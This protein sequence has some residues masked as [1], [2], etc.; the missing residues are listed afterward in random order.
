MELLFLFWIF[1]KV[2]LFTV[3]GGLAAIPLI[4]AEVISREWLTQLQFADMIAVSESTPGPIGV[5]IATYVGYSQ[6]GAIGSVVATIG[7]VMPSVII[8]ILI[9]KLVKRFRDH[10]IV[11]GIFTGLRPAVTGLILGAAA[12]I[13]L[14]ALFNKD[15]YDSTGK[16]IDFINLPAVIMFFVF[17]FM[18]N[19]W[20]HHP[21]YYIVIAGIIGIFIF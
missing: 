21:I 13:S 3:G 17:L 7:I 5:N 9:A 20:K 8:I 1:F 10:H 16:V 2:G 19:K 14:I 4:Q 11:E 6:F 15:L 18:T 12:S